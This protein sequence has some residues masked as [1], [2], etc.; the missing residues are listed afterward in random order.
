MGVRCL[1]S[2]NNIGGVNPLQPL[3]GNILTLH[4]C[5]LF[6]QKICFTSGCKS[7]CR[8]ISA[9][10]MN[11]VLHPIM[12]CMFKKNSSWAAGRNGSAGAAGRPR[13]DQ[14]SS[15]PLHNREH[16]CR[17]R[18][19]TKTPN[20]PLSHSPPMHMEDARKHNVQHT[21]FQKGFI[22][23][24]C[25]PSG[26]LHLQQLFVFFFLAWAGSRQRWVGGSQATGNRWLKG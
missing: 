3:D 21:C 22:E 5:L 2:T 15:H 20:S 10:G 26:K 18:T 11:S 9:Y 16:A 4:F 23:I 8:H 13:G 7:G 19:K 17:L 24:N 25:S 6:L 12:L 1:P 14:Y